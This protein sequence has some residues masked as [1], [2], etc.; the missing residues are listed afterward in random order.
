MHTCVH[1]RCIAVHSMHTPL[2][3]LGKIQK[4]CS[5]GNCGLCIDLC[6]V[7]S[8]REDLSR[9]RYLHHIIW[10]NSSERCGIHN[11]SSERIIPGRTKNMFWPAGSIYSHKESGHCIQTRSG[12]WIIP[13]DFTRIH[14]FYSIHYLAPSLLREYS[15]IPVRSHHPFNPVYLV[16]HGRGDSV[17]NL[18]G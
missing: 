7:R 18:S 6:E 3:I 14:N 2:Y 12:K 1:N 4:P 9:E 17:T 11:T 8:N 5:C 15:K 16:I 13:A 10:R